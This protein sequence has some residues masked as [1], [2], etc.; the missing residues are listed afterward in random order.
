PYQAEVSRDEPQRRRMYVEVVL[1]RGVEEAED[2]DRVPAESARSLDREAP[3]ICPEAFV[4]AAS[5]QQV[6]ERE[7]GPALV[8]GLQGGTED[9]R[10]VAH[11]LRRQV[12]MLHEALDA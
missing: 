6:H 8:L 10:Q 9:T 1:L 5:R 7:S 11:V 3:A 2:L 4:G 12:V